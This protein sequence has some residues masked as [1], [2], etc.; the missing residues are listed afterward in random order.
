MKYSNILEYL[1]VA[2][3]VCSMLGWP[4]GASGYNCAIALFGLYCVAHRLPRPVFWYFSATCFSFIT[5]IVY[6]ATQGPTIDQYGT[7]VLKCGLAFIAI[8]M[9]VKAAILFFAWNLF[10]EVGG[11][12]AFKAGA[13]GEC[14]CFRIAHYPLPQ[15]YIRTAAQPVDEFSSMPNPD[16]AGYQG[17]GPSP[18]DQNYGKG[19]NQG[20]QAPPPSDNILGGKSMIGGSIT[21]WH[22]ECATTV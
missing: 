1:Q 16:Q 20:Y 3:L 7:G 13:A 19:Y 15:P 8:N 10:T 6:A 5:D 9:F 14:P 21:S 17:S 12:Y 11:L 4:S 22:N 2:S 18:Y